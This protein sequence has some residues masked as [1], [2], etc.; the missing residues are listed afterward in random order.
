M[1]SPRDISNIRKPS[2]EPFDW[3][4]F[5][6]SD[7]SQNDDMADRIG[8]DLRALCSSW[9][10]VLGIKLAGILFYILAAP[11]GPLSISTIT[12]A[13][14]VLSISTDLCIWSVAKL[15]WFANRQS[16]WQLVLIMLA[17]SISAISFAGASM[18][19]MNIADSPLLA[20]YCV[21]YQCLITMIMAIIAGKQ[22]VILLSFSTGVA[23]TLYP[24]LPLATFSAAFVIFLAA[25]FY[26]TLQQNRH[27]YQE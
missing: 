26:A 15:G 9:P 12:V 4:S 6:L 27:D 21:I 19:A 22:R 10:L 16:R 24:L 20:A 7:G 5:S 23:V 25:S 11:A 17:A 2:R 8:R 14:A 1:I 3:S 18:S 13:L